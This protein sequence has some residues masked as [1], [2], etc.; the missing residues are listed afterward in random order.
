MFTTD[1]NSILKTSLATINKLEDYSEQQFKN[2]DD[3]LE[4]STHHAN[5]HKTHKQEAEKA[6]KI[7][8]KLK[9]IIG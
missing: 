1:L 3:A 6:F 4:R 9:S 8:E 5:L 7:S 2:A